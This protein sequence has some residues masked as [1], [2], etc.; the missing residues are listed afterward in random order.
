MWLITRDLHRSATWTM[1]I[2]TEARSHGV[3]L[4]M[5]GE[6]RGSKKERMDGILLQG[7]KGTPHQRQKQRVKWLG[8]K[9]S[10]RKLH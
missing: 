7:D 9:S 1:G 6:R 3:R 4:A 8:R 10:R 5:F 2:V